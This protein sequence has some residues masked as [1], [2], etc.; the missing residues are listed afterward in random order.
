MLLKMTSGGAAG[1][2]YNVD[3]SVSASVPVN[4]SGGTDQQNRCVSLTMQL[5]Q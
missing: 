2:S 3:Q 1:F 4:P 5:K